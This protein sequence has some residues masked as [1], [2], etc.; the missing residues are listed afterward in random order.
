MLTSGPGKFLAPTSLGAG[1]AG[2]KMLSLRAMDQNWQLPRIFFT[3]FW[4]EF[5]WDS[6]C[7]LWQT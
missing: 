1:Y 7:D 5:C 6:R 4:L 3:S 2:A